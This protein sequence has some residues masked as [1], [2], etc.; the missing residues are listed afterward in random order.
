MKLSLPFSNRQRLSKRLLAT[1]T[2]V[3]VSGMT[4]ASIALTL[5]VRTVD[6]T[7]A[8][9]ILTVDTRP[10]TLRQGFTITRSFVGRIE[11]ARNSRLGF[12]LGGLIAAI[13]TDDGDTVEA[14]QMVARLDTARLLVKR[15]E[16]VAARQEAEASLALAESTYARTNE[17]R[18]LNAVSEQQLDEALRTVRATVNR[19]R[20]QIDSIDVDIDKSTLRSPY[21]GTVTNRGVDEGA[22]VSPGQPIVQILETGRMEIRV[23]LSPRAARNIVP[24]DQFDVSVDG[25]LQTALVQSV[26]PDIARDSRTVEAVLTLQDSSEIFAHGRLVRVHLSETLLEPGFWLPRSA[27]AE[28]TRGLW[29]T[30][31]ATPG[32]GDGTIHTVTRRDLHIIHNE[33]DNVY[34]QGI[35]NDGDQIVTGGLHRIVPNQRVYVA[36]EPVEPNL[37]AP[38]PFIAQAVR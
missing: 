20:A 25:R 18:S 29:S 17:A 36:V 22:V 11:A 32:R 38:A 16:L 31:V 35:L 12:E 37:P 30:Y 27:L 7:E 6:Q 28:S 3:I 13:Y 21:A 4:A 1:T 9:R 34:V 5:S 10:A 24:G 8:R 33:E 19:I 14:G 23:G 26:L 15:A 2:A